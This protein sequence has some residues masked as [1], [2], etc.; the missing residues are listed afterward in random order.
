[1]FYQLRYYKG[2]GG[3]VS[4]EDSY[5]LESPSRDRAAAHV[6]NERLRTKQTIIMQPVHT[7]EEGI[8]PPGYVYERKQVWV[9]NGD[10]PG[11]VRRWL[12]LADT[13]IQYCATCH[14]ALD[15]PDDPLSRNCGGDCLQCMAD[16][17]DPD[18]IHAVNRIN[19]NTV[20]KG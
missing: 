18:C 20:H 8:A 4:I 16:A 5:L 9:P 6:T 11:W 15:T 13:N 7:R 10:D 17:G 19:G 2:Y 3:D 1:M 12:R 14:R